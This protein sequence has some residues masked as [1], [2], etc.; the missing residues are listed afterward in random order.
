MKAQSTKVFKNNKKLFYVHLMYTV[1]TI[2][3]TD[4]CTANVIVTMTSKKS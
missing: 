1:Y 4:E 2:V 3:Y